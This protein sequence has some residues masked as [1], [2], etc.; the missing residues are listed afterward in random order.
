VLTGALVVKPKNLAEAAAI[1]NSHGLEK[2][3]EYPQLQTVV[4]PREG[5]NGH[6]RRRSS[7]AVR[8]AIEKRLPEIIEYVRRLNRQLQAAA[9]SPAIRDAVNHS[10]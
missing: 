3:K 7:I 8:R 5:R 6:R 2:G 9:L 1:A 10:A 4:L